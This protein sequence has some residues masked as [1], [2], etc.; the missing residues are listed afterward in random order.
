MKN[1]FKHLHTVNKHRFKVLKNC[2]KLGIF[3]RGLVHDLSK[4]SPKEFNK[5]AKYYQGTSSPIFVQRINEGFY[6]TITIH[7]TRKNKH[8]FEYWVDFYNG[9]L[10]LAPMPYKYSLEYV[11]DVIAASQTYN[12]KNFTKNLPLEYFDTRKER[13]LMHS[14]TKLFVHTLLNEYSL[15]GFKNLKKKNTKKIYN[16]C[17]KKYNKNELLP[18]D[19]KNK[20]EY[21]PN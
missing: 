6:S 20:E 2:I 13:M 14:A 19:Y 18:I 17:I 5:S 3:W 7:H 8:H 9:K 4:Y 16:N 15:N 21:T 12:G 10:V 1:F 11:A